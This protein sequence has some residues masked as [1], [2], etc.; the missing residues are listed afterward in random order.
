M[1]SERKKK[2]SDGSQY[3]ILIKCSNKGDLTQ[4]NEWRENN[5]TVSILSEGANLAGADLRN[6]N[7]AEVFSCL[8]N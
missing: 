2:Q 3:V 7:L 1:I 5:Q 6:V 4:W 8:S